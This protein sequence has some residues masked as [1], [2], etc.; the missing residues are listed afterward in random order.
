MRADA[1]GADHHYWCDLWVCEG[2]HPPSQ[3]F[4]A[5]AAPNNVSRR[6]IQR[7]NDIRQW[8]R[9]P[10]NSIQRAARS[11]LYELGFVRG[12]SA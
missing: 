12:R 10:A 5:S 2:G 7:H 9:R 3:A 1:F 4:A 6:A 8:V 11:N